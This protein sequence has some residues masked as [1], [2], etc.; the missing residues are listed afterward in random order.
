MTIL[1]D[2]Q[3]EPIAGV[4]GVLFRQN[5]RSVVLQTAT[6]GGKTVIA[7]AIIKAVQDKK[8][9]SWFIVPRKELVQQT[10]AHFEKWG[11]SFGV[12]DASHKESRA[13]RAH[14][15][16]LQTL[17]RR[18]D[19]IKEWPQI[20]FFDEAHLNYDLQQKI[21]RYVNCV[22]CEKASFENGMRLCSEQS[23]PCQKVKECE[24]WKIK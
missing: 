6:G 18:L 10:K 7:S 16:S 20:I 8:K 24:K 22:Y 9:R 17:I 19:K 15:I 21:M 13:Y 5:K 4:R 11:I 2:Y 14:I 1:R 12:I 3:N 23:I